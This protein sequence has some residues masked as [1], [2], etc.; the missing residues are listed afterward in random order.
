LARTAHCWLVQR[1][2]VHLS[3]TPTLLLFSCR[4]SAVS[5]PSVW[6]TVYPKSQYEPASQNP[7]KNFSDGWVFFHY[8]HLLV[9]TIQHT[10]HQHATL[11]NNNSKTTK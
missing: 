6:E 2:P 11:A 3:A 4:P 10:A 7:R 9:A 1:S 8:S 5:V